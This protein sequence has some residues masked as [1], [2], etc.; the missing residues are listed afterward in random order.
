MQANDKYIEEILF[1]T[2]QLICQM[3]VHYSMY[4]HISLQVIEYVCRLFLLILFIA[5]FSI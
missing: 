2:N 1:L 4:T 5:E 3:C